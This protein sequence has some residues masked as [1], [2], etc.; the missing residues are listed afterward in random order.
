MSVQ[1]A[2]KGSACPPGSGLLRTHCH[3]FCLTRKRLQEKKME[4]WGEE[5]C[6]GRVVLEPIPMGEMKIPMPG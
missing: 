1:W 4:F 3:A 2:L 6:Q 5:G